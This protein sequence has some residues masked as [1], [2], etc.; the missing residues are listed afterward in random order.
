MPHSRSL[1][2]LT[3]HIG[4]WWGRGREGEKERERVSDLVRERE[5]EGDRERY[6]RVCDNKKNTV[7]LVTDDDL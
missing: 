7:G 2:R 4:G 3:S 6:E 5:R 1:Y